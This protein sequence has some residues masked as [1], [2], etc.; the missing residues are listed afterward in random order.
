MYKE[1]RDAREEEMRNK[2]ECNMEEFGA[3]DSSAETIATLGDRGWPQAAKQEDD[4]TS[5]TF[6]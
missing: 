2:D 6:R 5:K 4:R 3:P 1:G